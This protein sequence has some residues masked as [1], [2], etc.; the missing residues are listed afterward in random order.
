MSPTVR[1]IF[2]PF[3]TY[4]FYPMMLIIT[5]VV[6]YVSLEA[7]WAPVAILT[8]FAVFR[9]ASLLG[10]EFLFPAKQEWKMTWASFWR[11]IKYAVT[12]IAVINGG[13]FLISLLAL[14]LAADNPGLLPDAPWF[15]GL[16]ATA[17]VYEFFQY[18][19]HRI[20]HE[21]KGKIGAFLWKT[22]AAH[23]LPDK[24]YLVMHGV[25]HPLN[26]IPN[27]AISSGVLLLMGASAEALLV[28]MMYRGLH[29][30][31]T[32][33]N[34]DIRAGWLNY[35]FSG[36]ELHRFHHS[37]DFTEAKNYG[38]LLVFW[39]LV[40]GTF[41]YKPGVLPKRLGVD[42]VTAYPESTEILKVLAMPFKRKPKEVEGVPETAA[43]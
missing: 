32:H 33:F 17:L 35:I 9:F 24:V 13:F 30:W 39:D 28:L 6:A 31:M 1:Q 8:W 34:V 29:G 4:A 19:F 38:S 37:A 36:T 41:V 16:I 18:W 23:H 27:I 42:D 40:F 10:I 25:M 12:N 11:D 26:A 21:G 14:E 20:N 7:A 3:I 22:H 43:E 2:Q 15:V 5:G